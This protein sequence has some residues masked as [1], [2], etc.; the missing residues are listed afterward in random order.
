MSCTLPAELAGLTFTPATASSTEADAAGRYASKRAIQVYLCAE[1]AHASVASHRLGLPGAWL[2][3][4][5][6]HRITL[7]LPGGLRILAEREL[8]VV[9]SEDIH[10]DGFADFRGTVLLMHE[11][12]MSPHDRQLLARQARHA[13]F[14]NGWGR[15]LTAYIESLDAETLD[16]IGNEEAGWPLVEQQ[17][18][19]LLRRASQDHL[20]IARGARSA[21]ARRGA[22]G[23]MLFD[24]ICAWV[25]ANATNPE[26]AS[27]YVA[28]HFGISPRYI[29]SLF[30][31]HGGG[32]TFV[33][34]LREQRLRRAREALTA[35][36]CAHQTISE[37]SWN[38]G[39][40]D[41]VH[42]GKTFREFFGVTP[43]QAR[44]NPPRTSNAPVAS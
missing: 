30:A 6:Q 32:A 25:A 33:S 19:A 5:A 24:R 29:Q 22:R 4:Y 3:L 28:H 13:N 35:P 17:I 26:M 15:L 20:Y 36:G 9:Y 10:A 41:P 1:T 27:D 44:R 14:R 39:F 18:M 16:S 8:R 31:S 38:C 21:S 11:A 23:E 34:F 7:R 42:F 37:I 12:S 2:L 40:S 43:G